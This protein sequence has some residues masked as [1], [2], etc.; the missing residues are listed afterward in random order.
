MLSEFQFFAERCKGDVPS[1]FPLSTR[2]LS[3]VMKKIWIVKAQLIIIIFESIS[4]T[5]YFKIIRRISSQKLLTS[6]ELLRMKIDESEITLDVGWSYNPHLFHI[7]WDNG[8]VNDFIFICY[9]QNLVIICQLNVTNT[10]IGFEIPF[11]FWPPQF[12]FAHQCSIIQ[13]P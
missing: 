2:I 1:W 5:C 4:H 13:L 8:V 3:N 7:I 12:W 11:V 9:P 6:V 10:F